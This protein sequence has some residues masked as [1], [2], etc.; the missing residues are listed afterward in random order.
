MA[1]DKELLEQA[2]DEIRSFDAD[3]RSPYSI[4][5]LFIQLNGADQSENEELWDELREALANSRQMQR[6]DPKNF[7]TRPYF[8]GQGY[9]WWN[10]E[11]WQAPVTE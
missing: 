1:T 11:E 4:E 2:I 7:F 8:S 9:W 10:P 3:E 5:F 6:K